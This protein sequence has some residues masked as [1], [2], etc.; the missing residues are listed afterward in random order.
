MKERETVLKFLH[1]N[2]KKLFDK[3]Q[4]AFRHAVTKKYFLAYLY[5]YHKSLFKLVPA[6]FHLRLIFDLNDLDGLKKYIAVLAFRGSAKSTILE[7]YAEW[8]LVT[9]RSS[10]TVWISATADDYRESLANIMGSIEENEDLCAE[11]GI[12]PRNKTRN[13]SDRWTENQI[14][15]NN[16]TIIGRSRGQKLRGRKFKDSR[17]TVIIVDDLEDIE[18]TET[19]AKRRATRN[20]FYSE[21]F[22]AMQ[23][24]ELGKDTKLVMLGNLVHKDCLIANF[25][26]NEL[27]TSY[28]VPIVD[29]D[30][31]PTWEGMYPTKEAVENEKRQV[32]LA[33]EG[34]GHVVWAREFLLQLVDEEDQIIK[35]G[36]IHYYPDDWLQKPKLRGGVGVDLAISKKETADYTT[37]TKGFMVE[38]D[39]GEQRLLIGKNN[40]CARLDFTETIQRAK[41]IS[42]IM[43][44]NTVF[45]VENVAYQQSAIEV[46]EKN[47]LRVEPMKATKDKRSRLIAVSNYIK[48]GMVMFP[49]D[50][51]DDIIEEL[52]GFGIEEHDDR[53]DSLVHLIKGMMNTERVFIA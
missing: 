48:T 15:I 10:F 8:I 22:N 34:L 5:Y 26:K 35:R 24:G 9:G 50:G 1:E 29:K 27:V 31:N 14:T 44:N 12:V 38:N 53:V 25:M 28:S 11:W 47:G 51:A 7:K 19:I 39:Y 23:K 13:I 46:M 18:A 36:D 4:I 6:K 3:S 17:I 37:M 32:M 2:M 21:V 16:C 40:V 41:D 45:Y 52:L 20:W 30:G 43:P 49:K 42:F 33:G